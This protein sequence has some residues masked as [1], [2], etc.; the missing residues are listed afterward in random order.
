MT[1][2]KPVSH[3]IRNFF[4]CEKF[5]S[6]LYLL[7]FFL[8]TLRSWPQVCLSLPRTCKVSQKCRRK[9]HRS[10]SEKGTVTK[11][12]CLF[13]GSLEISSK[14]SWNWKMPRVLATKIQ[15]PEVGQ[16]PEGWWGVLLC[17]SHMAM[18]FCSPKEYGF[19]IEPPL[20]NNHKIFSF[21]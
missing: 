13:V 2:I 21:L 9:C 15:W 20:Q 17:V 3:A 12:K 5:P 7:A 8:D 4:I 19:S 14:K 18:Y 10:I 11:A 16:I 6:L 1:P